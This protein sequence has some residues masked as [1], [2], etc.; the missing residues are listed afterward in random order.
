VLIRND[1]GSVKAVLHL[2]TPL[3]VHSVDHVSLD[4]S[5]PGS[6]L[7]DEVR[8]LLRATRYGMDISMHEAPAYSTSSAA[9]VA[10]TSAAPASGSTATTNSGERTSVE[11]NF[12]FEY[13]DP[14]NQ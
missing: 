14:Q 12:C 8:N 13:F 2:A 11:Y 5:V 9:D 7:I 6:E 1:F 10:V 4:P 3:E